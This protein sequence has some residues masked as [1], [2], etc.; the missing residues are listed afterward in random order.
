[1]SIII[2]GLDRSVESLSAAYEYAQQVNSTAQT[3]VVEQT[4]KTSTEDSGTEVKVLNKYDRVEISSGAYQD[5]QS[6]SALSS[7]SGTSEQA[8]AED[9]VS[10]VKQ[11]LSTAVT[12]DE[13]V[14]LKKLTEAEIKDLVSDGTITQAQAN[15]ELLRR[16]KEE[17]TAEAAATRKE[18][19]KEAKALETDET[20]SDATIAEEE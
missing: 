17:Q 2:A 9:S 8:E 4:E 3:S 13:T 20:G 6:A 10:E 14:D 11:A 19:E 18:Q 12:D 15:A 5:Y 7:I 1:M 16:A